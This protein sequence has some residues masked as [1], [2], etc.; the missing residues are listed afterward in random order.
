MPR[1]LG[2]INRAKTEAADF[3][4]LIVDDPDYRQNLMARARAGTLP[5]AVET[6]LWYYAW[7]RPIERVAIAAQPLPEMSRDEMTVRV[8]RIVRYLNAARDAEVIDEGEPD[9]NDDGEPDDGVH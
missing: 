1:P 7:G 5:P 4:R 8:D 2:S 6:L 9:G 3:A